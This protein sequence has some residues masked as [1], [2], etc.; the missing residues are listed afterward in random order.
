MTSENNPGNRYP[1]E[2]HLRLI[3]WREILEWDIPYD[4]LTG[5]IEATEEASAAQPSFPYG[6]VENRLQEQLGGEHWELDSQGAHGI[7]VK[8]D[9]GYRFTEALE[10][11]PEEQEPGAGGE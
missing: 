11:V 1:N 8:A 6:A 3:T 5:D 10:L 4:T 9:P 7:I 2:K